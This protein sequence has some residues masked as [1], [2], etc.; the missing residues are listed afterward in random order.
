MVHPIHSSIP[1][2]LASRDIRLLRI[3]P[4]AD[5][6]T[7]IS[8]QLKRVN[9][10]NKPGNIALLYMCSLEDNKRTIEVN[11]LDFDVTQ[12]LHNALTRIRNVKESHIFWVDAVCID[13][14]NNVEKAAQIRLISNIFH[15]AM[16]V[17]CWLGNA[18][19]KEEEV[20]KTLNI[21]EL[22][23]EDAVSE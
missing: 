20:M 17:W 5:L 7:K 2:S 6:A 3:S 18:S 22:Q 1:L 14:S 4:L 15:Y 13:Q 11:S 21:E 9:L 19:A 10:D 8:Y 16:E 23:R 12:N